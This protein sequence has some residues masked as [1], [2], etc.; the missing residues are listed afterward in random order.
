MSPKFN[1]RNQISPGTAHRC[2][3]INPEDLKRAVIEGV[4]PGAVDKN[5]VRIREADL[6]QA[7]AAGLIN[8]SSKFLGMYD[9]KLK[10]VQSGVF[11]TVV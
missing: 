2:F 6:I 4:I 11:R 10:E 5:R 7:I 3:G 9:G 1:P 8:Q